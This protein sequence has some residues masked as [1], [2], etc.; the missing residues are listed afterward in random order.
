MTSKAITF[1]NN[2]NNLLYLLITKQ[3][4]IKRL[5][6]FRIPDI[7][8]V[9]I[10][11][12]KFFLSLKDMRGPSYH[13]IN[14]GI[15]SYEPQNISFI[16]NKI[17]NCKVFFDI[18]ANVGIYSYQLCDYFKGVT[19]YAFEPNPVLAKILKKTIEYNHLPNFNVVQKGVSS[20]KGSFKFYLDYENDGGHSLNQDFIKYHQNQ[21]KDFIY[22]ETCTLDEFV[23]ENRIE[24]IDFIKI[25]IQGLEKDALQGA[26]NC[27]KL[28]KPI[29]LIECNLNSLKSEINILTLIENSG[30]LY[31]IFDPTEERYLTFN[32]IR[33]SVNTDF[34]K[35][36]HKDYFFIPQ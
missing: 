22:I 27:L 33:E 35:E 24:K 11:K 36:E 2:F 30:H 25:D 4:W 9:M 20:S 6:V 16:K 10:A 15:N 3:R 34:T 23:I 5:N 18:G 32:D 19:I 29:L 17:S 14:W 31:K 12:K 13:I 21:K 26:I 1:S 8:F 7:G 28:F